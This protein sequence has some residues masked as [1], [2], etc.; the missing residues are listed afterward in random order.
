MRGALYHRLSAL[1]EDHIANSSGI[2]HVKT[3]ARRGTTVRTKTV[4]WP[5]REEVKTGSERSS[6]VGLANK[7][8][9]VEQL[10]K[11]GLHGQHGNTLVR[12]PREKV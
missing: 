5:T 6:R 10:W 11:S 2:G 1:A 7:I 12:A 9:S 4:V 3:V 8:Q